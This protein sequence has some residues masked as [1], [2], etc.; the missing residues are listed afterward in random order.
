MSI[1]PF[2]ITDDESTTAAAGKIPKADSSGKI[3]TDWSP[4]TPPVG[5]A[6]LYG[7]IGNPSLPNLPSSI[8]AL[9]HDKASDQMFYWDG[10]GW[11]EIVLA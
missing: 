1:K 5:G 9:G 2:A 4:L 7:I 3:S 11:N 10:A 6:F 8:R